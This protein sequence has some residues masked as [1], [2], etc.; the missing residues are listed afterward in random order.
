M[1][2]FNDKKKKQK[3]QPIQVGF[4]KGGRSVEKIIK[5]FFVF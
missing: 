1:M 5:F 2:F 3:K 4:I